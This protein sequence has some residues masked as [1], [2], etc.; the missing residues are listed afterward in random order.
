MNL[1]IIYV[2]KNCMYVRGCD[3]SYTPRIAGARL[4]IIFFS[5]GLCS[6]ADTSK[7]LIATIITR[8][9]LHQWVILRANRNR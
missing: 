4:V 1:C 8:R 9:R 3:G 6:A 5:V 2:S 7:A